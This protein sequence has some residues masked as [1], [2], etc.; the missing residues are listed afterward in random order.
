MILLLRIGKTHA[1]FNPAQL[2]LLRAGE[3]AK[4]RVAADRGVEGDIADGL[5]ALIGSVHG[6]ARLGGSECRRSLKGPALLERNDSSETTT[7]ES[8]CGDEGC[9]VR[10]QRYPGRKRSEEL[11]IGEA[12]KAGVHRFGLV[13]LGSRK[14]AAV[15]VAIA[16][17]HGRVRHSAAR[18]VCAQVMSMHQGIQQ[19]IRTWVTNA[20]W[21]A[22]QAELIRFVSTIGS[23]QSWKV[24]GVGR[25]R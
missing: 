16:R 7:C 22:S 12:S 23:W 19:G 15:K 10:R 8:S 13:R 9:G 25:L 2:L 24:K 6:D 21:G 5:G 11:T 20:S 4:P 17:V 1:I 3:P 14:G 18:E